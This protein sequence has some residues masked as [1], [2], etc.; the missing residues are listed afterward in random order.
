MAGCTFE[1]Q[2][3]S[4]RARSR[5]GAGEAPIGS[6]PVAPEVAPPSAAAVDVLAQVEALLR[7][8][9]PAAA[10]AGVAAPGAAAAVGTQAQPAPPA[11]KTDEGPAGQGASFPA[12]LSQ[13]AQ[14][15]QRMRASP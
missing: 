15:L 8:A 3:A 14:E 6:A 10:S 2:T 11:S 5:Q 7:G 1:P 13:V 12:F 9:E 4:S